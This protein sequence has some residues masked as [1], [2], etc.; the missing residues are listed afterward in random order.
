V[1]HVDSST[2][3]FCLSLHRLIH[4][5]CLYL[6]LSRFIINKCCHH[7]I[8]G[9]LNCLYEDSFVRDETSASNASVTAMPS[10]YRVSLQMLSHWQPFR[11]LKLM[12]PGPRRAEQLTL[13]SQQRIVATVEDSVLRT[14]MT[15]LESQEEDTPKSVLF[16]PIRKIWFSI[17]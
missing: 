11:D 8:T 3:A 4:K 5:F 16:F 9:K 14:E 12:F 2:L 6:S 15:G 13:R 17:N 10:Q 1:R 7:A